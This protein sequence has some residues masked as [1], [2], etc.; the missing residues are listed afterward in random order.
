MHHLSTKE[1]F[2]RNPGEDFSKKEC[3]QLIARA[4]QRVF[5]LYQPAIHWWQLE[6]LLQRDSFQSSQAPWWEP[7]LAQE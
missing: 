7:E 4:T 1:V 3:R 5:P 2:H 6:L